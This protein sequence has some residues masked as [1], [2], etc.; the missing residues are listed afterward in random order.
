MTTIYRTLSIILIAAIHFSFAPIGKSIDP[1]AFSDINNDTIK[2]ELLSIYNSIQI[3]TSI[4]GSDLFHYEKVRKSDSAIRFHHKGY[5]WWYSVSFN[6]AIKYT[7]SNE[8][9]NIGIESGRSILRDMRY[10]HE[11]YMLHFDSSSLAKV[12]EVLFNNCK[13]KE[14]NIML[15]PFM[16]ADKKRQYMAIKVLGSEYN[17]V[18]VLYI[19]ANNPFYTIVET[20]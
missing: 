1:I 2:K 12:N 13:G 7:A 10:Y 16:S 9:R 20:K 8:K 18:I 14:T 5:S 4:K 11:K 19:S 6:A 17:D 15:Q 3:N